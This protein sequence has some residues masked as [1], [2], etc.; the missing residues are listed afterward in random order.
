[1]RHHRNNNRGLM[2]AV[3]IGVL[4][5]FWAIHLALPE[6]TLWPAALV[7]TIAASMV[8]SHAGRSRTDKQAVATIY[9][10]RNRD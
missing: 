9:G 3:I 6:V 2:A 8:A 10:D 5:V 1:M 7:S 4:G